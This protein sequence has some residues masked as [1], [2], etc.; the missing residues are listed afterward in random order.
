M[1]VP[2]A[3]RV[4]ECQINARLEP[5]QLDFFHE[6]D[7]EFSKA[8]AVL[9]IAQACQK[10]AEPNIGKRRCIAVAM[11]QADV[12]HPTSGKAG[13]V[14]IGESGRCLERREHL[15]CRQA[16]RVG[17]HGQ[18]SK[19]LYRPI[20]ELPPHPRV[21]LL[22]LLPCRVSIPIYPCLAKII[23]RHL[24]G[25]IVSTEC[26]VEIQSQTDDC[27]AVHGVLRTSRQGREPFV[28]VGEGAGQKFAFGAVELEIKG[29]SV[30]YWSQG[31]C[32]SSARP[33]AR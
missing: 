9:V 13:Q 30:I 23:E 5:S 6:V 12:G 1:A 25:T 2:R 29:E 24:D 28:R 10:L 16:K 19:I 3:D 22:N 11:L 8:E 31:S 33:S 26:R 32:G 4:P 7:A 20:A 18:S 27:G 21:F 15:E 14:L 17:H